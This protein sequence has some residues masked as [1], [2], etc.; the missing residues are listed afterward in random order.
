MGKQYKTEY[1]KVCHTSPSGVET[2]RLDKPYKVEVP[3]I[4]TGIPGVT[5]PAGVNSPVG[6]LPWDGVIILTILLLFGPTRRL[7]FLPFRLIWFLF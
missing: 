4:E 1:T 3:P 5:I 7:I 6:F 2:C